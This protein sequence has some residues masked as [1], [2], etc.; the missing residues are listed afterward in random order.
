MRPRSSFAL[1]ALAVAACRAPSTSSSSPPATSAA[2]APVAASTA[3]KSDLDFVERVY[4]ADANAT[5]PM[6]VVLH[7][8]G[9]SPES[10]VEAFRGLSVPVRVIAARAP[11]KWGQG[12]SWFE[13]RVDAGTVTV[14]A[15]GVARAADRVAALLAELPARRPTAGRPLVSGFSQ[16][17]MLS[18]TI[19]ARHPDSVAA[20]FP[21]SGFLPSPIAPKDQP[22]GGFPPIFAVHGAADPRVDVGLARESVE[23]LRRLGADVVLKEY[24]GVG[25]AISLEMRLELKQ[26]LEAALRQQAR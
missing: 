8:L 13:T 6:L 17:G 10:F 21:I 11:D 4:N 22:K 20:A 16:G 19:A 23:T 9:D 15:D 14:F 24:P 25:H 2:I 7:G 5:L 18:Y 1:V 3:P 12:F 26:R